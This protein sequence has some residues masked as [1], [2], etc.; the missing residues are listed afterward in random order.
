MIVIAVIAILAAL[1]LPVLSN[2]KQSGQTVS[3]LNN[4]RQLIVATHL[5]ADSSDG[6]LPPNPDFKSPD[7]WVCGDM[8]NPV[9][10]TDVSIL[11][12]PATTKLAPYVAGSIFIYKCPADKTAHDRSV[13]MNQTVGTQPD[14]PNRA[15]VGPWLEGTGHGTA[16]DPWRTYGRLSDTANGQPVELWIFIDENQYTINDAFALAMTQPTE[17]VDWPGT[18][19]NFG[20]TLAFAD[21]HSEIHHWTDNRTRGSGLSSPPSQ[22]ILSSDNADI[23]WLQQR[24]SASAR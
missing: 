1:L 12:N 13:S 20:V 22:P 9:E 10:A 24:T 21:G 11:R 5:Y 19:H 18:R 4:T 8:S 3:C 7:V 2:A 16:N 15:V 17:M 14:P 23:V 6:W